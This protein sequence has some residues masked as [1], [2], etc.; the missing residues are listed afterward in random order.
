[1]RYLIVIPVPGAFENMAC[2]EQ[3]IDLSKKNHD[4]FLLDLSRYAINTRIEKF[5][6]MLISLTHKNRF[7]KIAKKAARE[8][9]LNVVKISHPFV[10]FR[11]YSCDEELEITFRRGFAS[12]FSHITGTY[13][14]ELTDLPHD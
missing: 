9:R 10:L 4:V 12:K 8:Y 1:M 7:H 13:K 14:T 3:A 11:K 6:D 2:L 5:R